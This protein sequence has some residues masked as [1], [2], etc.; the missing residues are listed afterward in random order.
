[1]LVAHLRQVGM[2]DVGYCAVLQMLM[3]KEEE[4][5][6][7]KRIGERV[8]CIERGRMMDNNEEEKKGLT[9]KKEYSDD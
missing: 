1:M 8:E 5:V 3:M 7:K 4:R 6:V 9:K 2:L